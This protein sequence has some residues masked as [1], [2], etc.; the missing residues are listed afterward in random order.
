MAASPA[1]WLK[2]LNDDLTETEAKIDQAAQSADKHRDGTVLH[3]R[4]RR[5]KRDLDTFER[6]AGPS[7]ELTATRERVE[8]AT[9]RLLKTVFDFDITEQEARRG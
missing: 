2:D 1:E 5:V 3:A 9:A 6:D 4:F 7:P 8:Q